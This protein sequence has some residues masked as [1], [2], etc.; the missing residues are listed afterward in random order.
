MKYPVLLT[1]GGCYLTAVM[2]PENPKPVE[3][4]CKLTLPAK[5]N[6]P[7]Q[8]SQAGH[9]NVMT[10]KRGG[11]GLAKHAFFGSS[12]INVDYSS[13]LIDKQVG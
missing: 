12:V 1:P 6:F 5:R 9:G 4:E 7:S 13:R 10:G 3:L 2:V 11:Q 8:L